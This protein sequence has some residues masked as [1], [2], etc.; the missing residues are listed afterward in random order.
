VRGEKSLSPSPINTGIDDVG[1]YPR[2][3]MDVGDG[4]QKETRPDRGVNT[5]SE[6]EMFNLVQERLSLM[7]VDLPARESGVLSQLG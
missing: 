6:E 1:D 4:L 5:I 7:V 2:G 3:L